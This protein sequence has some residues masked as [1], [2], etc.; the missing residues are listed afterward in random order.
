MSIW[1]AIVQ[2]PDGTVTCHDIPNKH[3]L[4]WN[5]FRN[6]LATENTGCIVIVVDGCYT[7]VPD[8]KGV[9]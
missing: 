4:P 9:N 1:T 3:G 2:H 6:Q 7:L 5:E 8:V